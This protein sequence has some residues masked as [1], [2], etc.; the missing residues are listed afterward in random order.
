MRQTRRIAGR[1][2]EKRWEIGY[3]NLQA[4]IDQYSLHEITTESR[5]FA[6]FAA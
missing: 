6:G 1:E 2:V 4:M 5:M 3:L